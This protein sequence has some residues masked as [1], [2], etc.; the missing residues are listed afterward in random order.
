MNPNPEEIKIGLVLS[1]LAREKGLSLRDIATGAT[2]LGGVPISISNL[3]DWTSGRP[4]RDIRKAKILA[5]FFGVSLHKMLYDCEENI[6]TSHQTT[7]KPDFMNELW[8]GSYEITLR[9]SKIRKTND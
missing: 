4:M 1:K 6:P 8:S 7:E 9:V 2:K 5:Q 3:S